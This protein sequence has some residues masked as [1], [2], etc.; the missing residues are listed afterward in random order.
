VSA[1]DSILEQDLR[2]KEQQREDWNL[3][4]AP[5]LATPQEKLSHHRENKDDPEY[6]YWEQLRYEEANGLTPC[7][8]IGDKEIAAGLWRLKVTDKEISF[9]G[10]MY[11]GGFLGHL[12]GLG[13]CK[14]LDTAGRATLIQEQDSL[15]EEVQP[16]Q[17]KDH[18]YSKYIEN[19]KPLK[20]E[21]EGISIEVTPEKLR[22]S[23]LNQQ[24]LIFNDGFL[25]HL[26][27]HTKPI[28]TDTR[29]EIFIPFLNGVVKVT[30]RHEELL[31]YSSLGD[32]CIWRD[33]VIQREYHR[34]DP[35]DG[36]FT[37]FVSN[38]CN[39][40]ADRVKALKSVTGYLLH[41]YAEPSKGQVGILYD[42]T[43]AKK[44]Q[45]SGGTGKGLHVNG[46][47]QMRSTAKIDGKKFD[48]KDK[49][50]WQAVTRQTDVVWIDDVHHK[51]DF[52][53]LH[54]C[55]TDG[56]NIERKHKDEFFIAPEDS[57]KVVIASNT[58]LTSQGTTNRR[59]QFIVEFSDHYSSKIIT[60]TEEPIKDEHGCIFF[61]DDW[62]EAEWS[63]F[64]SFMVDCCQLYL[65]EGLQPYEFENLTRNQ[66]LQNTSDDFAEWALAKGFQTG[67]QYNNSDLFK[68]FRD[69]YYGPDSDLKQRGFTVWMKK[70][71]GINGWEVEIKRSNNQSIIMF[72]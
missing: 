56:W 4:G 24:H 49:F 65:S 8:K 16:V 55:S 57:P 15:I 72:S 18:F 50:R 70:L 68:E 40:R 13:Y 14:R 27:T 44:G 12:V 51:F 29:S 20:V 10:K 32:T 47:R 23:Y 22:E 54:S 60:G 37:K 61:S 1:T 62:D 28:L 38:V 34:T 59:R 64:Y 45:P 43:P 2:Q 46:I 58:I 25:E 33:H 21:H 30:D 3:Y 19:V 66:L 52:S 69:T 39:N 71:A 35:A 36:H 26:P 17:I 6:R 42:E 48:N 7:Q 31:P 63:K 9:G 41:R 5:T 67:R 53:V 11:R